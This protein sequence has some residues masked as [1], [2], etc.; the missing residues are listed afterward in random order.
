M[1]TLPMQLSEILHGL[2][3]GW[4]MTLVMT[5]LMP[6]GPRAAK[7]DVSALSGTNSRAPY[8]HSRTNTV[9]DGEIANANLAKSRIDF[10]AS[11]LGNIF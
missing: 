10:V 2:R 1:K 4:V 5:R 7:N 3:I 8:G 11:S 9:P 6:G